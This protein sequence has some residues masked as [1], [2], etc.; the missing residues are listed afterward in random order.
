M[1][2]N[3]GVWMARFLDPGRTSSNKEPLIFFGLGLGVIGSMMLAVGFLGLLFA[4]PVV[5]S[6]CLLATLALWAIWQVRK[7]IQPAL[8]DFKASALVSLTPLS[9][10]VIGLAIVVTVMGLLNVELGWDALTYHLRIPSF[11]VYR[12]KIYDVWH[13]YCAAFP[14]NIEMLYMLSLLLQGDML[15][16]FL[17]FAVGIMLLL[18]VRSLARALEV[19]VGWAMLL[20]AACPTFLNLTT[21]AYIDL[22]FALFC[23]LSLLTFLRWWSTGSLSAL[24]VSGLLAG[25][26]M[27]SKYVGV[28]ILGAVFVAMAP[29][30]KRTIGLRAALLWNVAAFLPLSPWLFKNWFFKA[31]P[32]SPFLQGVFGTFEAVP[33]QLLTEF[34]SS[35]PLYSFLVSLPVRAEALFLNFGA[36]NGPLMPIVA[37]LFPLLALAKFQ[38]LHLPL[39]RAVLGFSLGWFIL[40][41]DVRFF[42]PILPALCVLYAGVIKSLIDRGGVLRSGVR[43]FLEASLIVGLLYSAGIQWIFYSPFSMPLGFESAATKLKRVLPP[44]PFTSYLKDF[45]NAQLPQHARILYLSHFS[46]Y[47]VERECIA[48][49]HF[50]Q[51]HIT[52]IIRQGRTAQGISK[53]LRQLGIRWLLSTGT[54][55]VQYM[56]IPGFFDVPEGGWREMKRLLAEQTKVIWQTNEYT[57][58]R[59]GQPHLPRPLPALPVYEA[60]K[61]H[62][63]DQALARGRVQ[64]ALEIYLDAPD[65]LKDVGSTYVRQGDAL[66]GLR[67]FARAARAYEHARALGVETPRLRLGLALALLN[68]GRAAAALPHAQE[69][70]RQDPLSAQTAATLAGVYA[71]M[72]QRS[73]AQHWIRKAIRLNPNMNAYQEMAKR[74][75]GV[76]D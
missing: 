67:D 69:A 63:A 75:S 64:E 20:L 24:V 3:L 11:Y 45:A 74:I 49:F 31:N 16:R 12:H 40:C 25:W 55:A 38:G 5:A 46:T 60:L 66:S 2:R 47:F 53:Q 50:G 44:P 15:A 23:T 30:L 9:C 43:V 27:S 29:R 10:M 4:P 35:R 59:L 68:Q 32:V 34:S 56:Q 62:K 6:F 73:T 36:V 52:R 70:W 21:R 72:G 54:G 57:L 26:G 37:G 42:L 65:L 17:N 48:D 71:T 14:S 58:F 1:A 18:A 41:P 22:G 61:F 28:L 7:R 76:R 39:R 8:S 33:H 51:A 13:H 19:P